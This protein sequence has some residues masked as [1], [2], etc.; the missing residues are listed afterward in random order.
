[1]ISSNSRKAGPYAGDGSTTVFPFA[2]KVFSAADVQVVQADVLGFETT[3][4][5]GYNVSLNA[6]Q[7]TNPGG[8][9][10]LL[11]PLP[12]T[13]RL[14]VTSNVSAL[15]PMQLTNGGGFFPRVLNDSADRIIILIQQLYERI[16]RT[17]SAPISSTEPTDGL[18]LPSAA[19]RAGKMLAFDAL[20]RIVPATPSPGTDAG[21]RLDLASPGGSGLVNYA[22]QSLTSILDS[23]VGLI[24]LNPVSIKSFGAV[25]NGTT[26]DTAAIQAAINF[27]I[28]NNRHIYFPPGRYRIT[29]S[30]LYRPGTWNPFSLNGMGAFSNGPQ[31][32]G[33]GPMASVL[34]SD[35]VGS[36]TIRFEL[37]S[38][39]EPL[40]TVDGTITNGSNV[41]TSVTDTSR[42]QVGA[43]VNASNISGVVVSKTSTTVTL[44]PGDLAT[45][46]G[47]RTLEFAFFHASAFGAIRGIGIGWNSGAGTT[48][49]L[50]R[51]SYAFHVE[52]V[53][54]SGFPV[55]GMW[56]YSEDGDYD[57]PIWPTLE[58]VWVQ[59][60]TRW[61]VNAMGLPN[62]N[63][64]SF[65]RCIHLW[66][67]NC[68]NP[69]ETYKNIPNVD[70][71]NDPQSGGMIWKGQC[72][73]MQSSGFTINNVCQLYIKGGDG[74]A[75][76]FLVENTAFENS[77]GRQFLVTG[78]YQGSI[79]N[80]H[81]Y[82]SNLYTSKCLFEA[83][84]SYDMGN[85][86]LEN[87]RVRVT[88]GSNP[89]TAFR[90]TKA[91]SAQT[92]RVFAKNIIWQNFGTTG[93]V[94][95]E[96]AWEFD[97]IPTQPGLTFT[98]QTVLLAPNLA[99]DMVPLRQRWGGGAGVNFETG[100]FIQHRIP[101]GGY[102]V[103]STGL[104]DGIYHV[105]IRDAGNVTAL[106]IKPE[107][108]IM[109][110]GYPV[111]PT[112]TGYVWIG[113]CARASGNLVTGAASN[114]VNPQWSAGGWLWFDGTNRVLSKATT[115][116]IVGTMPTADN[117]GS[118]VGLQT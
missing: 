22:G 88:S 92:Q 34:V 83:Y 72:L 50:I 114:W 93:Q 43:V 75:N 6:N 81:F 106:E 97:A 111:H 59:N 105:Y 89:C 66:V 17:L 46:S 26:D 113:R 14:V 45:A 65:L 80:C 11:L 63:E 110:F 100:D 23:L 25:G 42:V 101:A 49:M 116:R 112:L 30:L 62:R 98:G 7:D 44:R 115:S 87:I 19:A 32:L 91:Y 117:N 118:V 4:T 71:G 40:F 29:S 3:L 70:G 1:M 67:Q 102:S 52:N 15:Q 53:I 5:G 99:G 74:L 28:S 64:M 61:G 55:D 107:A 9:V 85:I 37:P 69:A 54:I 58:R 60:C 56:I 27:G 33:A 79:K 31:L 104:A 13:N 86:R 68:G 108:P 47:V 103:D 2:F 38:N 35:V 82:N 16:S 96:G 51:S 94:G 109:Q 20:G 21:I 48:G 12:V 10:T 41:L 36:Y 77:L 73:D 18:R 76:D 84:P 95:F 57:A 8:T 90:N 39:A 24:E 78:C